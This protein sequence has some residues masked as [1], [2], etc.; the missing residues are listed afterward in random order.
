MVLE[1]VFKALSGPK[2]EAR[3]VEGLQVFPSFPGPSDDVLCLD[4]PSGFE[5][6]DAHAA[7]GANHSWTDLER[8][9][10]T[11]R[12][13]ELPSFEYSKALRAVDL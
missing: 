4:V 13:I 8:R 9:S 1:T 5:P 3:R 11:T 10:K 7:K 12:R 6:V 2:C